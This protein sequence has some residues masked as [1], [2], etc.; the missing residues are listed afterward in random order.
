MKRFLLIASTAMLAA[1]ATTQPDPLVTPP[2]ADRSPP[3]LPSRRRSLLPPPFPPRMLEL[4]A[5]FDAVDKA[6]LALSPVSKGYRGI[7]DAGLRQLGRD[8]RRGGAWRRA[9]SDAGHAAELQQR[10]DRATLSPDDQLSYDL[11]LYRN[12]RSEAIYPYREYGYVFDQMNGAQSDGPAFLIN[13]HKVD[14]RR[15]AEAYVSRLREIGALPRPGDRRSERAAGARRPAAQV[16]LPL[17]HRQLAQHHQRRAIH[18]RARTMR[19]GPTSRA[20]SASSKP[21]RRPRSGCSTAARRGAARRRS[22]RLPA[23]DRADAGAAE[24]RA[25]PTTASGASPMAPRNIERC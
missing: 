21:M 13:I 23:R 17:C 16:G 20:R 22:A 25:A 24:G 3:P 12:A 4:A 8:Q 6:E 1:C 11:F 7:N 19:C 18:G 15:D 14:D 5:F 9:S 10:F 2:D